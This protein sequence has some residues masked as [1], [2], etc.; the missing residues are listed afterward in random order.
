MGSNKILAH[1]FNNLSHPNCEKKKKKKKKEKDVAATFLYGC[2]KGYET[3]FAGR[4]N[5]NFKC[6]WDCI[7]HDYLSKATAHKKAFN[8]IIKSAV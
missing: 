2:T 5:H 4:F 6:T 3:Q 1:I 7:K 8:P